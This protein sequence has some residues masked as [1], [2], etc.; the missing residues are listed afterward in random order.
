[1]MQDDLRAGMASAE[2][3]A[4]AAASRKPSESQ[5]KSQGSPN[6]KVVS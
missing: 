1:M 4:D 3:E 2:S 6:L 5:G